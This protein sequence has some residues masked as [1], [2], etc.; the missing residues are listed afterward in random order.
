MSVE[1]VQAFAG[2]G[3]PDPQREL[4]VGEIERSPESA[5]SQPTLGLTE[6][7]LAVTYFALRVWE[8]GR[9]YLNLTEL[10]E[11]AQAAVQEIDASRLNVAQ[12]V[13]ALG[14]RSLIVRSDDNRFG[15]I[16]SSVRD[17]L[18]AKAI[19]T[20]LSA[21]VAEPAPPAQAQLEPLAVACPAAADQLLALLIGANVG[22][23]V[24]P[25]ASLATLLCLE[26]CRT[27]EVRVPMRRFVLTGLVLAV[28]AT[29]A[30]TAGLLLTG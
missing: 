29:T 2:G 15:F 10:T 3:I 5:S 24:T 6:L 21:G 7:W 19:A 11:V 20:Q 1:G 12:F 25:W 16:H 17:W 4:V 14:S 18:V 8:N 23:V 30:A 9:P 28:A 26:F 22:P 27:H 13:H